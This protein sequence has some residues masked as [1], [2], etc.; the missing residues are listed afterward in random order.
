MAFS[1]ESLSLLVQPIG[2]VGLRIYSYRTDDTEATVTGAGYATNAALY[3]LRTTDLVIV[4]P[5]TLPGAS[6]YI[7]G[8][9]RIDADGRA[10]LANPD[11]IG[12]VIVTPYDYGASP[13]DAYSADQSVAVQALVDA[14]RATYDA[15]TNT[16]RRVIDLGGRM[17]TVGTSINLTNLRQVG[18]VIKNGGLH[19]KCAGRPVISLAGTQGVRFENV[20]IS[21]D[22]TDTPSCAVLLSR[23]L[24]NGIYTGGS[25]QHDLTGLETNGMFLYGAILNLGSEDVKYPIR[26]V[27]NRRKGTLGG[28]SVFAIC[29]DYA[30]FDTWFGTNAVVCDYATLP[31]AG[32]KLS[33]LGHEWLS[34]DARRPSPW[35]APA[36]ASITQASP[37]RLTLNSAPSSGATSTPPESGD[38]TFFTDIAGMTELNGQLIYLNKISNTVF[39]LYTDFALTTPLDT[40]GYGAF[41]SGNMWGASGPVFR[42]GGWVNNVHCPTGYALNYG[43]AAVWFDSRHETAGMTNFTL[44]FQHEAEPR[45]TFFAV[46]PA[47][48]TVIYED[49]DLE[50]NG[51]GAQN[52]A[53]SCF[54]SQQNGTGKIT[55]RNS[56]MKF[57]NMTSNPAYGV[58]G[59]PT[60]FNMSNV[61]LQIGL[62]AAWDG[63]GAFNST[64]SGSVFSADTGQMVLYRPVL[65]SSVGIGTVISAE[66]SDDGATAGPSVDV[67]RN[68]ASPAANDLIGQVRL[69]GK[70]SAGNITTFGTLRGKI[71]DPTD[72]SEDGGVEV[73][74]AIGGT[75][76][77]VAGFYQGLA[78]GS[79]IDPGSGYVGAT[80]GYK[81]NNVAVLG[82]RKTGWGTATG[83]AT[84][85]TFATGSVTLSELA[86]RVKALIDDLHGTAGHGIIGT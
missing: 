24:F 70:D 1:P 47:S 8:V 73:V 33:C 76:S 36:I 79:A 20:F 5:A 16:F 80:N 52:W 26:N 39:D 56:R 61:D 63:Q 7:M 25:G 85:T 40:T 13:S 19:G 46:T 77:F 45:W 27:Y 11:P 35:G 37:G 44:G 54:H 68:S 10:T 3:G 4:T 62:A 69:C 49:F 66:G 74:T 65:V 83:T 60:T 84:R 59:D 30:Y 86:E 82:A 18:L 64:F 57:Q 17:W 6:P 41:S 78:V 72:G 38:A 12:D 48:V 21:G 71:L 9:D 55:F 29:S 14:T 42:F 15:D 67:L 34:V 81:V 28:S 22:E 51:I 75:Q 31:P 23:A 53:H 32:T 58:F 50:V 43:H 2:D